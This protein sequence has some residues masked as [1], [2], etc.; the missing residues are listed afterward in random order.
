MLFALPPGAVSK[1]Q[2]L[3]FVKTNCRGISG[4]GIQT[5]IS[6]LNFTAYSIDYYLINIHSRINQ[7][8]Q[9]DIRFYFFCF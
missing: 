8:I 3:F 2:P 4:T 6:W 1:G 9:V 5:L 7:Q